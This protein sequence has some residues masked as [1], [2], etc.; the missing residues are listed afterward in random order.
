[1]DPVAVAAIASATSCGLELAAL[2]RGAG[3]LCLDIL[4]SLVSLAWVYETAVM[5]PLS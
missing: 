4:W 2:V 3:D 1:M 5:C